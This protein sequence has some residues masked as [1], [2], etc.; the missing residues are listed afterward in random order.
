MKRK[1]SETNLKTETKD[2]GK[3]NDQTATLYVVEAKIIMSLTQYPTHVQQPN[4]FKIALNTQTQ[5]NEN[6]QLSHVQKF[7]ADLKNK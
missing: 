6:V 7:F 4:A 2:F 1:R 3:V 5:L